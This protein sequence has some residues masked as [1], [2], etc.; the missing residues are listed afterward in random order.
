[1]MGTHRVC[2]AC[3]RRYESFGG[4]VGDT[5]W[6]LDCMKSPHLAGRVT[7]LARQVGDIRL[8]RRDEF[9]KAAMQGMLADGEPYHADIPKY[10]IKL[11][12][13]MIAAL[14]WEE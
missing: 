11:A 2:T 5:E 9:A 13:A 6:C 10:A 1:M 4:L 12:D 3:D 7:S 14:D 8:S